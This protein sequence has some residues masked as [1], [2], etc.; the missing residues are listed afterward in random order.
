MLT[1]Y[2]QGWEEVERKRRWRENSG[3]MKRE[4]QP[5]APHAED[6]IKKGAND[7]K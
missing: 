5:S 7:K 2:S 4:S 3:K 1:A 6:G